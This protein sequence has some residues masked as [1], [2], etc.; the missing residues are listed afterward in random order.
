MFHFLVLG[1]V[2]FG[3][4]TWRAESNTPPGDEIVISAGQ[5]ESMMTGFSQTWQRPPNESELNGLIQDYV[6]DEI[7]AREGMAMGLHLNDSIIRRRLRQKLEFITEDVAA[8]VAPTDAELDAY[9]TANL[10]LFRQEARFSF[11]QVL[12]D[13]DKRGAN[14]S[15]DTESMLE[16]LRAS[17][18]EVDLRTLSDSALLEPE[19]LTMPASEVEKVFGAE[20]SNSLVNLN[21]GEWHRNIPSGFGVHLV[22]VSEHIEGQVPPLADIRD[23]VRRAWETARRV[24][25]KESFYDALLSRYTVVIEPVVTKNSDQPA[26]TAIQ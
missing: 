20:F 18:A 8:I 13:P 14:L 23:D 1:G 25:A 2:L 9:Y 7:C 16:T 5:I 26:P 24:E 17:N 22:F 19:Y 21:P 6:R 10:P 12:L 15:R 4:Y 3:A 11:R